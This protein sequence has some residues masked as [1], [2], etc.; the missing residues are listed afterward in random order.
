MREVG[1]GNW[2]IEPLFIRTCGKKTVYELERKCIREH[3]ADL[4]TNL[5]IT[6][7]EEKKEYRARKL[8]FFFIPRE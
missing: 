4:N 7:E 6:S 1:L 5:P 2:E 3:G 8:C